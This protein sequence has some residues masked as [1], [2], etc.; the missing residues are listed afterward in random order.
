[1]PSSWGCRLVRSDSVSE[2]DA[3]E[4]CSFC[5]SNPTPPT[6]SIR[7]LL[8]ISESTEKVS[9][10]M[11]EQRW[12]VDQS[13]DRHMIGSYDSSLR[14]IREGYS[15][16]RCI[17]MDMETTDMNQWDGV[18]IFGQWEVGGG[19]REKGKGRREGFREAIAHTHLFARTDLRS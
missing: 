15:F 12:E 13:K 3:D 5:S 7:K 10:E 11:Q 4:D 18:N 1:M 9:D 8:R 14:P 16:T 6:R 2:R 17:R 19:R